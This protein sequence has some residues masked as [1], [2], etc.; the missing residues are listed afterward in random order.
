MGI[1]KSYFP[2]R[3]VAERYG[4]STR[5][6]DR[7]RTNPT[8]GF[9]PPAMEIND[10]CYWAAEDLDAFDTECVRRCLNKADRPMET[11]RIRARTNQASAA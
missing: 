2:K 8:V 11:A 1:S 10:R 7:W 5:A 9:P 6:V 3:A 4:V